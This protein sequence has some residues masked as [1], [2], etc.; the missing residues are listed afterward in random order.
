MKAYFSFFKIRF[1]NGLQYRAAAYAGIITQFAWGFMYIMLYETFYKSNPSMAPMGFSQL[2]TYIWLQQAFLAVFMTWFLDNDIFDLVSS[3]N[4][5]YELCRPMDIYNT[6]F[7]KSCANRLSKG[8]LRFGPILGIA[9]LLPN[10]Y[11][12][13]LPSSLETFLLFLISMILGLAVVVAYTMFIYIFTFYTVSPMGARMVFVMTADFFAGGLVPL[14]LLPDWLT[15]YIYLTPFAS[16][17]NT[18]FRVYSGNISGKEAYVSICMQG[19]WAVVLIIFGKYMMGRA[20][21][22]VVVQGG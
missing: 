6:W 16:M 19:F 15:K 11:K 12:F 21:K 5:A 14:P 20:L 17:Q 3:G 1:I 18:P 2:S 7:S 10:P 9:F 22:N 13:N 4:V 8:L